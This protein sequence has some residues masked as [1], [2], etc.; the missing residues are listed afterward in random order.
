MVFKLEN[1]PGGVTELLEIALT[2]ETK[3]MLAAAIDPERIVE[4]VLEE[5]RNGSIERLETLI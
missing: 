2:T 4:E 1:L 3:E 5:V